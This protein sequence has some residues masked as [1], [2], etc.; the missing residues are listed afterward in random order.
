MPLTLQQHRTG[1]VVG[2]FRK[3]QGDSLES[4]FLEYHT[5]A[6][7]KARILDECMIEL[8]DER[9]VLWQAGLHKWRL[10]SSEPPTSPSPLLTLNVPRPRA[11]LRVE[12][13]L[14]VHHCA[15]RMGLSEFTRSCYWNSQRCLV[16]IGIKRE[17]K[18]NEMITCMG[19]GVREQRIAL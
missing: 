16:L 5:Y 9:T 1:C 11:W 6:D 15:W 7:P 12:L 4:I 8:F 14:F 18:T 2:C 10:Q 19:T 3:Y 17:M 13:S